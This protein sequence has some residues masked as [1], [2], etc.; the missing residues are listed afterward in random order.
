LQSWESRRVYKKG[1]RSR[2]RLR[3]L[4][5]DV[6]ARKHHGR[7]KNIHRP[8][9]DDLITPQNESRGK[10]GQTMSISPAKD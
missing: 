1:L 4:A 7:M 6:S 5:S 2:K 9:A 10:Q 8:V 3:F